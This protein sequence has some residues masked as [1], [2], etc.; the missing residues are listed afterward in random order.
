M[1]IKAF[2]TTGIVAI[3]GRSIGFGSAAT[4][5][6]F[7]ADIHASNT[8]A[9]GLRSWPRGLSIG[10]I[11]GT[12]TMTF[13]LRTETTVTICTTADIPAPELRS[14]SRCEEIEYAIP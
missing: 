8:R 2:L 5:L 1:T 13:T 12:T 11:I 9:I 3:S 7:M 4:P 10:R 6:R 14:A